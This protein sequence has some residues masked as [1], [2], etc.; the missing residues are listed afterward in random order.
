MTRNAE[1][2]DHDTSIFRSA[3]SA[4]EPPIVAR[5]RCDGAV[6]LGTIMTVRVDWAGSSACTATC[7]CSA[8]IEWSRAVSFPHSVSA[9]IPSARREHCRADDDRPALPPG[10]LTASQGGARPPA[11]SRRSAA[12]MRSVSPISSSS[13][14]CS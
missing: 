3:I 13:S 14:G 11:S 8:A 7:R 9:T 5:L 4:V 1:N 2:V 12:L 6:R 10:S